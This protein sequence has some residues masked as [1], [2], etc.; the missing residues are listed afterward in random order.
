MALAQFMQ[1]LHDLLTTNNY[2]NF[3]FI[4]ASTILFMGLTYLITRAA[5][6]LIPFALVYTFFTLAVILPTN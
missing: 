6:K 1:R 2:Y 4:T 5:E 3:K